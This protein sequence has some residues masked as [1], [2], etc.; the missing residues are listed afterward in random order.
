LPHLRKGC[1]ARIVNITSFGGKL[2]VPHLAPYCVSKF[3]LAGFSDALRAELAS[4]NIFVTTVAPGLMRTGSHKNAFFKGDH[5]KEFTWFSLGA[6]NPLVSMGA[7]RAGSPDIERGSPK[8]TG[9]YCHAGSK[10][11]NYCAGSPSQFDGEDCQI[12]SSV[13]SAIASSNTK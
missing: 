3:A 6:G 12:G 2:A 1:A 9:T 10:I 5:Q 13:A 8:K 4:K 7:D 11:S